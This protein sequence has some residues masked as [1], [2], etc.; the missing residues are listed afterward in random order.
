MNPRQRPFLLLALASNW[1]A[2][3]ATVAIENPHKVPPSPIWSGRLGLTLATEPPQ[4]FFA[5]FELK[6]NADAGELTLTSPMGSVLAELHWSPGEARLRTSQTIQRSDSVESLSRA[7]TGAALPIHA[8]FDWLSGIGTAAGGWQPDLSQL[9]RGRL[10]AR[11]SDPI[12]AA[13]L[14]LILD[15]SAKTEP[16]KE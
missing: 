16:P 15:S 11:R 6:G 12:P 14:K 5:T 10:L 13:E 1:L 8:L 3:C 4:A 2:G 9:G 7:A